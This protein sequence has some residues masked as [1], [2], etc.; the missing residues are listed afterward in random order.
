M[1]RLLLSLGFF[2]ATAVAEIPLTVTAMHSGVSIHGASLQTGGTITIS[3][4][5]TYAVHAPDNCT[6]GGGAQYVS[7]R[8]T[9]GSVTA[10]SGGVITAVGDPGAGNAIDA[11]VAITV[12]QVYSVTAWSINTNIVTF[13]VPNSLAVDNVVNLSGFGTSTFFNG[14]KVSV[15][16]ATSTQ[17]TAYFKH[18]N[19]SATEAGT[20]TFNFIDQVNGRVGILVQHPGDTWYIYPTPDYTKNKTIWAGTLPMNVAVGATVTAGEGYIINSSTSGHNG[21]PYQQACTWASSDTSKATV[22]P[23]GKVTAVAT[24][25][26]TIT[27]GLN[28]NANYGSSTVSGWLTPGN[29][30]NL[31]IVAGGTG[32]TTWYVRPGGSP[33]GI[34]DAAHNPTGGCDGTHDADYVSG[35]NQPCAAGNYRDL[36]DGHCGGC[37]NWYISGG[38]TV[39]IRQKTGGYNLNA[40]SSGGIA[41]CPGDNFDC[42]MP[43]PPSG[44]PGHPTRILGENFGS[45]T[46]GS[47][48]TQLNVSWYGFAGFDIRDSQFLDIECVEI[49]DLAQCAQAG[50]YTHTCTGSDN[51]GANGIQ[52]S[53][54]TGNVT[55]TDI[56]VHG[57]AGNGILGAVGAGVVGTRVRIYAMPAGGINMDDDPWGQGN[58]SVAGGLT[59]NFSATGFSGC[60]EQYPI[61]LSYPYIECRDQNTGAG[62]PDG[63]GTANT[64]GDWSFDH[65]L[66]EYNF[67]DGLDLLHSGMQNLSVTNSMS[68]GNDGQAYK[69]G[70]ANK[71]TFQNNWSMANCYRIGTTIGDEPPGAVVPGVT[72]CR[73]N[74]DNVFFFDYF[75]S[76]KVQAS[77]FS[78]TQQV[79]LDLLVG[80]DDGNYMA[81]YL[82]D[83]VIMPYG[84]ANTAGGY[85][86]HNP[87]LFFTLGA[88]PANYF[89]FR[90]HNDI[91][92]TANGCSDAIS[93]EICTSPVW[94]NQYST[95]SPI[96]TPLSNE[97]V[98]DGITGELDTGSPLPGAGMLLPGIT[99]DITGASRPNPPA[100]GAYEPG[101]TPTAATP[102]S[103]LTPGTYVGA[104]TTTLS[105]TTPGAV[106]CYTTDGTTPAAATP[107]TCSHG[108]QIS[109]GTSVS[110]PSTLT[111]LA[112]AT[113]AGYI[114]SSVGSFA[115][116]ITSPT[117]SAPT[118]S[119]TPGT[120][121]GAQTTTLSTTTTGG[122]I[123]YTTDG[124]TPTAT[125]PGTCSHGTSIAGGSGSVPI[126]AT[127]TIK[128]LTTAVGYINSGVVSFAYTITT[129]PPSKT[130]LYPM[131]LSGNVQI[132]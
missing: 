107:G 41:L 27:C 68:I 4:A 92:N 66:W 73:A 125:T 9:G 53:A 12:P 15:L 79:I 122:V 120:Y 90:D 59:W 62:A 78:G 69:I 54:L 112:I 96:P 110:I 57:L 101:G 130:T 82:E 28:G 14:Q 11:V 105:T 64:T 38:D 8:Q 5:C 113:N 55:L 51:F 21:A 102:T 119:L 18:G 81:T 124:S 6:A 77:S 100:I 108:T 80:G 47:A 75:G 60:V 86:G 7:S 20:G 109:S 103:S 16:S 61:V 36:W 2:C 126:P 30:I 52:T 31:T 89:V 56:N 85:P 58:L 98:L 39:I 65:D 1:K 23:F 26:V 71:V 88:L 131:T 48:K 121:V 49:T 106:I 123:C 132:P 35:I 128:A 91:F 29:F 70:S 34:Y 104:Q 129:P 43:F 76:T 74:D 97:T 45:C 24:G 83:D 95:A 50:A 33:N 37:L 94:L 93:T 117:A 116:T 19:G 115:Y 63:L 114:N 84:D 118:S 32:T 99:T 111:I 87:A 22:D 10:T 13:T 25:S 42:Q 127:L 44:S 17:F 3:A 72:L 67:Q 40:D 46:S